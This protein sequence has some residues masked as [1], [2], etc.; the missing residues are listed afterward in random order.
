M[1]WTGVGVA[2][3]VLIAGAVGGAILLPNMRGREAEAPVPVPAVTSA[4]D[5]RFDALERTLRAQQDAIARLESSFVVAE[6]S[7]ADAS[8]EAEKTREL[9]E[10][11]LAAAGPRPGASGDGGTLG[12]AAGAAIP[13]GGAAPSGARDP[14]TVV[15]SS[16]GGAPLDPRREEIRMVLQDIRA[17]E[18][19]KEEEREQQRRRDETSRYIQSISTRLN[20][21]P[22]QQEQM[23]ALSIGRQD[24]R[25]AIWDEVETGKIERDLARK[26]MEESRAGYETQLQQVLHPVQ[27]EE[28]QKI[29]AEDDGGRDGRRARAVPTPG[30][31]V[32]PGGGT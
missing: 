22:Q 9:L 20:L 10:D 26:K 1:N 27:Y 19:R 12:A 4:E 32:V 29:R 25:R 2:A 13:P 3:G 31:P 30:A 17:E 21:T 16:A 24:A 18:R 15:P 6:R 7:A 11:F 5:P 14:G 28:L 23:T 8:R